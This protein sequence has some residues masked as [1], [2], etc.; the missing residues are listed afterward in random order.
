MSLN[1][2]IFS[3]CCLPLSFPCIKRFGS[4][5]IP[6]FGTF[7]FAQDSTSTRRHRCFP[8]HLTQMGARHCRQGLAEDFCFTHRSVRSQPTSRRCTSFDFL[9]FFFGLYPADMSTFL[10][11]TLERYWSAEILDV[12]LPIQRRKW[13]I[14]SWTWVNTL[15]ETDF[16]M[17]KKVR[18]QKHCWFGNTHLRWLMLSDSTMCSAMN[19]SVGMRQKLL[20]TSSAQTQS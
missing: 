13:A 17:L 12:S 8:N 11:S 1:A 3:P 14:K 15:I 10:N 5:V 2:E 7:M 9:E 19:V 6:V 20:V 18:Y 4:T 16:L